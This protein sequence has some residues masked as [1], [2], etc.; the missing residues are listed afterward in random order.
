MTFDDG[1][2][3]IYDV[4]NIAPPGDMPIKKLTQKERYFYGYDRLG[5][6]RFYTALQA[7]QTITA[8]VNVPGWGDIQN[9]DV[10]I[11]DEQPE[12]QYQINLVQPETDENGLRMM[13][14]TLERMDFA[15]EIP[16]ECK[17]GTADSDG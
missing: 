17:T 9:T 12:I 10:A 8:V 2:L 4:T 13:K 1:I 16:T 14:L 6:T 11:L 3:T 5:I 7:N 15:Y